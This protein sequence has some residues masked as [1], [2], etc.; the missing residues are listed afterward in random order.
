MPFE[1]E[2]PRAQT[3]VDG[4]QYDSWTTPSGVGKAQFF[5]TKTGYFLRFPK[6]ADFVISGEALDVRGWPALESNETTARNLYEN[7]IEPL[8]A[9]HR[10]GM[11]LHG[12]AVAINGAAIAFLG[13]SRSGKTTLAG[14]FAKAGFPF[15]TEDAIDLRHQDGGYVLH[16]RRSGVRLFGD[17][18]DYLLG[19]APQ[20]R[21][22]HLKGEVEADH[23]L[24]F[25]DEPTP[26]QRIF[27]LGPGEALEPQ[28]TPLG[29]H[30]ALPALLPHSFVL[31]V[32][33]KPRLKGHFLRLAELSQV[34]ACH[35]L[36]YPRNYDVLPHV[37]TAV[38]QVID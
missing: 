22:Q 18:A 8:L 38:Q 9:N 13:L 26:L 6:E 12:A 2:S 36:D 27:V 37:I 10:G 29:A 32:E 35:T 20:G 19:E 17:S 14:A 11:F 31:D 3:P 28:I 33:D 24:P 23:G 5:R 1:L 25:S 15:L 16:P 30:A 34:I 21:D 4:E 7:S